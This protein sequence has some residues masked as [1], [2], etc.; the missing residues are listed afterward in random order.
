MVLRKHLL[1]VR[2]R[3]RI[4]VVA[5]V[6]IALAALAPPAPGAAGPRLTPAAAFKRPHPT[7][8]P[9]PAPS[10]SAT[11]TPVPTPSPTPTPQ[12]FPGGTGE[13]AVAY[14][15]DWA[16]DGA[17]PG[18]LLTPPLVRRWA[19]DLGGDISYPLIAGGRVFA[20][21]RF[22]DGSDRLYALDAVTGGVVWSQDLTVP[23]GFASGAQLAYDAGRVFAAN[24]NDARLWAFDAASGSLLW[25]SPAPPSALNRPTPP[26]AVAGIVYYQLG[27]VIYALRES[28]GSQV[29]SATDN[30]SADGAFAVDATRVYDSYPCS[31]A[32]AWNAAT[33][34]LGWRV[35]NCTGGGAAG[36]PALHGGRLYVRGVTFL[37]T[38][39][40]Y[41]AGTGAVL[42]HFTALTQPAFDG[43]TGFFLSGSPGG[44]LSSVDLG[45]GAINWAFAGDGGLR[46]NVLV[47]NGF[48]YVGSAS[49]SVYALAA[50]TSSSTTGARAPSR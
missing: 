17:Q 34:A 39:T 14:Q 6:V 36:T 47:A 4:V 15:N 23:G 43:S 35:E 48:V 30:N 20:S 25:Q 40:V 28:D 31:S 1:S 10:P 9:T 41:D 5:V 46:S 45:G 37:D 33:G 18:D 2:A 21:T 13:E 50:S 27:G 44:T 29:W 24:A 19:L 11:P 3:A 16:H 12:P 32:T 22:F 7:P 8:T 42:G 38:P 26:T 49:G